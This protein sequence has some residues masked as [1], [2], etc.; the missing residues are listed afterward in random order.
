V[1]IA[2]LVLVSRSF[3]YCG[4]DGWTMLPLITRSGT[5]L[6]CRSSPARPLFLLKK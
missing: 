2:G 5:R 6:N 4:V 3:S 1:M